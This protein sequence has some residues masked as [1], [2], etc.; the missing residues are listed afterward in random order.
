MEAI[1][2]KSRKKEIWRLLSNLPITIGEAFRPKLIRDSWQKSG[3][4]PLDTVVILSKC[5]LWA[6]TDTFSVEQKR[7]LIAGIP[8]LWPFVEARGR[9]SDIEMETKFP[10]LPALQKDPRYTLEQLAVNRDRCCLV[11][12]AGYYEGRAAAVLVALAHNPS[13]KPR[14]PPKAKKVVEEYTLYSSLLADK[15]NVDDLKHQLQI[16]GVS[17]GPHCKK[18]AAFQQ[19]WLDNSALPDRRQVI[20]S[21]DRGDVRGGAAAAAAA[22]VPASRLV[23]PDRMR[24]MQNALPPSPHRP[25]RSPRSVHAI[26]GSGELNLAG[27]T[28]S[29]ANEA[30]NAQ[31]RVIQASMM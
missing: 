27:L 24:A 10:F 26:S 22:L 13:L 25:V 31:L 30:M 8:D 11:T 14:A 23:S 15:F 5:S 28:L 17:W 9:V 16:R 20:I 2:S 7:A 4:I 18:K 21:D 1:I 6:G 3:Y 19:L 12:H 29:Q